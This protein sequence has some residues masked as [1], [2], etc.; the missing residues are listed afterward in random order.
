M[1]RAAQYDPM[2]SQKTPKKNSLNE[3]N[4]SMKKYHQSP[5]LGVRSGSNSGVPYVDDRNCHEPVMM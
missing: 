4:I 1:H 3:S 2:C 5:T